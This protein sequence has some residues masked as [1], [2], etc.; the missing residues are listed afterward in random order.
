MSYE[1]HITRKEKWSDEN[2]QDNSIS[3]DEWEKYV[4]SDSEMRQENSA[5]IMTPDQKVIRLKAEGLSVWNGHPEN[6]KVWFDWYRGRISVKNPD[7]YMVEKMLRVS[8][9]FNA[10]VLGDEGET[11]NRNE[12]GE[13]IVEDGESEAI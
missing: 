13:I 3:L 7:D 6:V 5:E 1:L 8:K 11:Y 12:K 9:V 4:A 2:S 10:R